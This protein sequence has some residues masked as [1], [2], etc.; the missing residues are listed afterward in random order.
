M[1]NYEAKRIASEAGVT[2]YYDRS[3]RLWTMLDTDLRADSGNG[4][5]ISSEQLR[6]LDTET[7]AAWVSIAAATLP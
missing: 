4:A 1:T 5:Y 7:F 2:F 6:N 3:I